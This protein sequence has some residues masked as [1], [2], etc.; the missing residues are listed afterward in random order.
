MMTI[1][2]FKGIYGIA[3][4]IFIAVFLSGCSLFSSQNHGPKPTELKPFSP[5]IVLTRAWQRKFGNG[6]GRGW[7]MLRP[8]FE[9]NSIYV[10]SQSGEVAAVRPTGQLIWRQMLNMRITGGV[11]ADDQLV[12]VG[13]QSGDLVA[14]DRNSGKQLWKKEISG[15]LLSS[16]TLAT[17]VVI[18]QS[19]NGIITLFDRKGM[20]IWQK[21]VA[22]PDLLLR[23][24]SSPVVH[25]DKILTGLASGDLFAWDK[26]SGREI[27]AT[28]VTLPEGQSELDRMVDIDAPLLVSGDIVYVVSYQG[29]LQALNIQTGQLLWSRKESSYQG[30]AEHDA[31]LFVSTA[32]GEVA[33]INRYNGG[34]LWQQNSL[35][36][37]FLSAPAIWK[38]YLIVGDALGYLH[39]L[40]QK[41]GAVVGRCEV[42]SGVRVPPLIVGDQAI[43]YT[44]TG[45]LI[46]LNLSLTR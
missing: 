27:W 23:G 16:P 24:A 40:S 14:L 12:V 25:F 8:V 26:Q 20:L 15:V 45:N 28:T 1:N 6:Q 2:S 39:V 19:I 17:N 13:T 3:A 36:H 37:R 5:Q 35:R 30:I 29:N 43:V 44:N 22:V 4:G 42:P 7:L 9:Q 21:R 11:A 32:S 41:D 31:S 34:S 18:A 46:A 38:S 10:A 33:A